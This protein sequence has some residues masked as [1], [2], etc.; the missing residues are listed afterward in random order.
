[1]TNS[2]T[3]KCSILKFGN[4]IYRIIVNDTRYKKLN[5]SCIDRLDALFY[6][7]QKISNAIKAEQQNVEI[8]F[9]PY[10]QRP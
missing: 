8:V 2:E 10:E 3:I 5:T 7:M 4:N 6:L 9:V 1:M